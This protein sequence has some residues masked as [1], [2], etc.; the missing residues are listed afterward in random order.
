MFARLSR[1][2]VLAGLAAMPVLA[3]VGCEYDRTTAGP[4]STTGTLDFANRLRHTGTGRVNCGQRRRSGIPDQGRF[5]I[6]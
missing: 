5:R 3:L 1:R 4:I 2:T 6:G